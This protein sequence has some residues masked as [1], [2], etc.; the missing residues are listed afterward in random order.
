M[1]RQFAREEENTGPIVDSCRTFKGD[2]RLPGRVHESLHVRC[3]IRR[4]RDEGQL[5]HQ[6]QLFV[7][8]TA[9]VGG[10]ASSRL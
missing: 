6:R 5:W 4:P 7:R 9:E 1:F 10:S 3:F 8:L 2:F